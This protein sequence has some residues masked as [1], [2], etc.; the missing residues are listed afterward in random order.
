MEYLGALA[1]GGG[2]GHGFAVEYLGV[3]A[4]GGGCGHGFAVE[5]LGALALGGDG[6]EDHAVFFEPLGVRIEQMSDQDPQESK[7][8]S[9]HD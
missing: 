9:T 8:S 4:L 6:L 3:L 1:L 2:C 7:Q 5:Y